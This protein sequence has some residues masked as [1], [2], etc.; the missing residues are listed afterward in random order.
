MNK[1]KPIIGVMGNAEDATPQDIKIARELGKLIAAEGWILLT[2]G[3]RAGVMLAAS[4]GAKELNGLTVGIIPRHDSDIA[5]EVDVP[6]MTDMGGARNNINVLSRTVVIAINI[7][8][9]I[10]SEISLALQKRT[11][12]PVILLNNSKET[13][14]FFKGLRGELVYSAKNAEEAI[15]ITKDLLS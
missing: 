1:R 12:K 13:T 14:A 5:D 9:G 11:S 6:I 7:G 15:K 10:S 2:G 4:Q 8:T 3:V